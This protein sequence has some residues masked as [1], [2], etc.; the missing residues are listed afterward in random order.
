MR[1]LLG[2]GPIRKMKTTLDA[3][4]VYRLP[5]GDAEVAM[6]PLIGRPLSMRFSGRI[7]CV[8][9][10]RETKKSFAQGYCFPC[11][12]SLAE[13]DLC[14]MRPETCHF[15]LGT[16]RDPGWA[17]D[18]C[19]QQHLVYIA[20]SSGLKVGITRGSQIPTRWIDQGA[21]Q[22][23]PVLRVRNRHHSG[24]I[25]AAIKKHV[26][27]RTDWRR[28]LK[29][30]APMDDFAERTNDIL[31]AARGELETLTDHQGD[32][33]WE[34]LDEPVVQIEYPVETYPEKVSSLGFDK[35]PD[36][37][38]LLVGIKGQYLI[39]DQGVINMR[40]FS[41]YDIELAA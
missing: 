3:P 32:I 19:M 36:V 41:G 21:S 34:L 38:G 2:S 33:E 14:I 24:L 23:I 10:G 31:E 17:Q 27:D 25:E 4:V 12:R 37:S 13:C 40:K 7:L 1:Q 28:M 22:A 30:I 16:C 26:S 15:H 8:A 39:L 5:L 11:F 29:G 6:N 35:T 20:N 9:C 18:H